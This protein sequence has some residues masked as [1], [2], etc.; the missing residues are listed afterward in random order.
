MDLQ[1]FLRLLKG[2][3]GPS[4]K[5]DYVAKCPAHDD[6]TASLCVAAGEKGIVIKCQAGCTTKDVVEAMGLAMKDLFYTSSGAGAPPAPQGQGSKSIGKVLPMKQPPAGKPP[7]QSPK[8]T[9]SPQGE[10][11]GTEAEGT[12]KKDSLGEIICTY[13]YTDE[14]GSLLFE[15]VRFR[16]EDGGKTFRQ[17]VKDTSKPGGYRWSLEGV[18]RVIFRLPTVMAAIMEDKPVFVVE[19]EK[20]CQTLEALGFVATTCP[21]GAGKWDEGYTQMLA[22]AGAVY[23]IPDNDGPLQKFAGQRHAWDVARA[24]VPVA[25]EVRLLDLTAACPDLRIKGDV[26][27]MLEQLGE[28][29]GLEALQGL[30]AS[31]SPFDRLEMADFATAETYY[32]RVLGYCIEGGCICQMP[33]EE[34]QSPK[35]L[36]NFVALPKAVVTRDDG[37]SQEKLMVIAGWTQSG[38]PLPRARVPAKN[39]P[40]MGWVSEHWDFAANILPGN[41]VKDKLRYVI[42]EVGKMTAR[43]TVEYSHSGW[44]KFGGKWAYLYQGGAIGA[45]R[46]TVDLGNGLQRY[47]LDPCEGISVLEAAQASYGLHF[48]MAEQVAVPLLGVC[49]LAPLREWLAATGNDPAF[50]LFLLGGTG[51]RKSTAAALALSHYGNFTSR[52]LPASFND[53]ANYIRSKA[54][55]LKDMPIVVDDYHPVTSLQERKK[56]EGIAQS[57]SRAF[58]DL[59][60]RGRMNA[61]R[62]LQ[63]SNPPR[64]VA[65]ISGEDMPA[66][67]QS[68]ASRYFL[69][70]VGTEDVPVG[71]ELTEMQHKAKAGHL[72]QAMRGYIE[73]LLPQVEDLP[74][75]LEKQFEALRARATD[76][77]QGLHSRSPEAIAQI[78]L[79]YGLMMKY[80]SD[81][82][83]FS[84]EAAEAETARAWKTITESSRQQGEEM[85][86]ERPSRMFLESLS[87]LMTAK[88]MILQDLTD[89]ESVVPIKGMAGY[90]DA[91][92]FYFLPDLGYGMVSRMYAD[93]GLA[94]PLS[95]RML[96]KQLKDDGYLATDI[97]GS[98]TTRAKN[99]DGKTVRL[100]WIPRTTLEGPA[101]RVAQQKMDMGTGY[102]VVQE[103][104]PFDATGASN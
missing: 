34:G 54:F 39:F 2:V 82:G 77:C 49:Y 30:M 57:L 76:A 26:T 97:S 86:D 100:L 36:A 27:D 84:A 93:Q 88:T 7:H 9:A 56:M 104:T 83:L 74:E 58:G 12:K 71:T 103:P 41:T 80:F 68:G 19:G 94:F 46:V 65:I 16:T 29:K 89:P 67:G 15:V 81:C 25:R 63:E 95:K 14:Q 42:A 21:M 23:V 3:R 35:R 98:K 85:K 28:D 13:P 73:W 91:Q 59:A 33:A 51:T 101:V 60:E 64:S 53:T 24:L 87:E 6:K 92:Y 72:R 52:S 38:V 17:R 62:S 10:A 1:A 8:A 48:C 40:G 11:K 18:R 31:T 55:R 4:E 50:S 45:D 32:Q 22:G 75:K 96:Y 70:A 61:D 79:G 44:R 66:V 5:G 102:A 43:R 78:M 20:D 69:V 47:R 37:V 90:M 99:I